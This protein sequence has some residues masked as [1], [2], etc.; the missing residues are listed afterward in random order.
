[1]E[2]RP[3]P[4]H[5]FELF[6]ILEQNIFL[7]FIYYLLE[8]KRVYTVYLRHRELTS[9][10]FEVD[11]LSVGVEQL[12]YR[13]VVVLH[14]AADGGRFPLDH[15]HVVGGQVQALHFATQ[16][17]NKTVLRTVEL[18]F[19]ANYIF[20]FPT[21]AAACKHI[22]GA[23]ICEKGCLDCLLAATS[24]PFNIRAM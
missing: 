14:S 7:W 6:F 13:V 24:N 3:Q 5:F 2:P 23:N 17:Q 11:G 15:G 19:T 4:F 21:R 12:D 22:L 18:I 16:R 1:M 9:D 10:I 20:S 8:R